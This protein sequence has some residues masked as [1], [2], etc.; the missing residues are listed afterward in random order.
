MPHRKNGSA[1]G[2]KPCGA[3]WIADRNAKPP[4]Y[5]DLRDESRCLATVRR[6]KPRQI[7][8]GSKIFYRY[9]YQVI[10]RYVDPLG[11]AI[12]PIFG[13]LAAAKRFAE[14]RVARGIAGGESRS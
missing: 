2:R 9:R 6:V 8:R 5:Y 10:R 7:R 13:S 4:I 14:R 12:G 11:G 3:Q 1:N